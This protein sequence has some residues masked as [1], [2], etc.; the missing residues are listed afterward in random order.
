[1]SAN[2]S[3]QWWLACQGAA[4]GPLSTDEVD[5]RIA[6]GRILRTALVCLVGETRWRPIA[7]IAQFSARF[8]PMSPP[9]PSSLATEATVPG[10]SLWDVRLQRAIGW[11]FLAVSPAVDILTSLVTL[12]IIP[13]R[14]V[15]NTPQREVELGIGFL[16]A[17]V[18]FAMTVMTAWGGY[19]LLWSRSDSVDWITAAT[20]LGFANRWAALVGSNALD[21]AASPEAITPEFKAFQGSPLANLE[22]AIS[23][24]LGLPMLVAYVFALCWC[25]NRRPLLMEADRCRLFPQATSILPGP[26][27]TATVSPLPLSAGTSGAAN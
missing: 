21:L 22:L 11:L 8:P 14:F 7:A 23:L 17:T 16:S 12:A 27:S 18:W 9:L 6:S 25:W 15:E 24:L 3:V 26:A 2:E 5:A 1:M 19:R 20:I 13:A 10:F 4:E